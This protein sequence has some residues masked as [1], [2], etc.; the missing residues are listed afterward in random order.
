MPK[1]LATT[2]ATVAGALCLLFYSASAAMA[3][4][5]HRSS[6]GRAEHAARH[7]ASCPR[8]KHKRHGRC[9]KKARR[10]KHGPQ[11]R[12][13]GVRTSP[14]MVLSHV[15]TWAYDDCGNG[16]IGA[17]PSL[18]RNWVTF[19]E[20]NCGP[21]GDDK[22]LS[23]CH[24]GSE[25]FCNVI[26]YL[27]T[28]WIYPNGSP[29]WKQ[30]SQAASENW[31]LHAPGSTTDRITT[32]GEGGGYL[33][34][35]SNSSVRAFFQSYVRSNYND[36][37]GLMMDDQASSLPQA[38]YY[39]TCHCSSSDEIGTASSLRA[40]H[41]AMSSAMTHGDGQPFVQIDNALSANPYLPSGMNM[42]DDS[43]GVEG[44]I[45][46]GD[47]EADGRMTPYYSTLL[48]DIA[49]VANDTDSFVVP[50]SYA[51]A[52]ASY[53]SES[54]RV[55]EATMLLGYSPGHLVDWADLETGS[56]NLGVWPEEGIYP[57]DPVQTMS[58]PH[59]SGCLS[60]NGQVCSG[61]GHNDLQVASGVYRREFS[62]C[63]DQGTSFGEC[64]AIVNTTS[65]AV[66]VKSSWLTQSYGHEITF[67][68]GDVQS[69]GTVNLTGAGFNAGSSTVG[70]HSAL[71]LAG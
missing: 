18:V 71:L 60:G 7:R 25:S 43:T 67:N 56:G 37:D 5:T 57:T 59:G 12:L 15:E 6:S 47:P 36:A 11:A 46:E 52:G 50:L 40:A 38:L 42:L 3:T 2:L 69:G 31:Y 10:I 48:D 54:R 51:Q 64:A 41:G 45:S 23:D 22:T 29:D 49:Y 14:S 13:T 17:S 58:A 35:Q 68:G 1:R 4:T 55:Q 21:G 61:G 28:N 33:I 65:N 8:N 9:V 24:S 53:Q 26:Q 62:T 70:P 19:A 20:A 66:T 27:D 16:G 34:D 30:F 39:A 32:D 44:L 63:Y